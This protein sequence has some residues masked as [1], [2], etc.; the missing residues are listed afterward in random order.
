MKTGSPD[1]MTKAEREAILGKM[2]DLIRNVPIEAYH[3]IVGSKKQF[4]K[5]PT[6]KWQ[7]RKLKDID[8]NDDILLDDDDMLEMLSQ[9]LMISDLTKRFNDRIA[10]AA[11]QKFKDPDKDSDQRDGMRALLLEYRKELLEAVQFMKAKDEIVP[12]VIE[13]A[14]KYINNQ[15]G[16]KHWAGSSL[17][18]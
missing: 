6:G 11:D 3:D 18:K 2:A 17:S 9:N 16:F 5:K 12:P 15:M 7:D 14:I 8:F 13:E 4:N 10:A 1:A